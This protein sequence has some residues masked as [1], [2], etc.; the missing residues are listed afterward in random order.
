MMNTAQTTKKNRRFLGILLIVL[1]VIGLVLPVIPGWLLI[2]TGL[3]M[4]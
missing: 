1:G 4:L 2:M 3:A